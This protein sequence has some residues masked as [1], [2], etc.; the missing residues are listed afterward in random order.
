[1]PNA[2]YS[3]PP[4][5]DINDSGAEVFGEVTFA[6]LPNLH[7]DTEYFGKRWC[8]SE[9]DVFK[10][11]TTHSAEPLTMQLTAPAGAVSCQ[12][13]Y[14]PT[15]LLGSSAP[16]VPV[17]NHSCTI[18]A[19]PAAYWRPAYLSATGEVV[20]RGDVQRRGL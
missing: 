5:A 12:A 8:G 18:T 16:A 20:S 9:V 4:V 6:A 2:S 11:K 7:A 17:A 10:F 3:G 15:A 13:E 19:P 1:W 14:G